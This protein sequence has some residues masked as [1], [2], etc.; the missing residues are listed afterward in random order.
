[1]KFKIDEDQYEITEDGVIHQLNPKPFVYDQNYVSC[2][3]NPNYQ[4]ESELLQAMRYVFATT[5]HGRPIRSLT[6]YGYGQ[7]DFMKFAKKQTRVVYGYDL[8]RVH[9][10]DCEIVNRL[11]PVDV[12]VFNDA[13]E[14]VPDLSF[15]RDL[16]CETVVISLPN[17]LY[18]LK[19][20]EW[21]KTWHHR[22]PAEHLHFFDEQSLIK[23]MDNMGWKHIATSRHEDIVRKRGDDWNIL[24]AGFKRK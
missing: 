22:K 9:V 12:I 14:H 6:D 20:A 4:K 24:T 8:T 11:L 2:Y 21:F 13:L 17:C 15:V 5:V 10:D 16:P 23:F 3:D 1:M 7:G 19:G 18:Y